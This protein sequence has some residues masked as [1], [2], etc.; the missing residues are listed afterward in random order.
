[1]VFHNCYWNNEINIRKKKPKPYE[2]NHKN[3]GTAGKITESTL[4][5]FTRPEEDVCSTFLKETLASLRRKYT[6][7]WDNTRMSAASRI[8]S[9]YAALS[10]DVTK[11][12][13]DASSR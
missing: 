12:S 13:I 3:I 1:M 2:I 11:P 7:K 9:F 4:M 5:L 8:C 6:E 10:T